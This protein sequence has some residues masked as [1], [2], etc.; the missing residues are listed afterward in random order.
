[1]WSML[2]AWWH[3]VILFPLLFLGLTLTGVMKI[4]VG[5][6]ITSRE[7]NWKKDMKWILIVSLVGSIAILIAVI[8]GAMQERGFTSPTPSPDDLYRWLNENHRP[9]Q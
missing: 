9:Q 8:W 4:V 2:S 1:M 5:N 6:A 7:R 3:Y